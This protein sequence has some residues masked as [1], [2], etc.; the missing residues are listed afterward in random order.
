[1]AEQRRVDPGAQDVEH[2]LDSR[3]AGRGQAPQVG[4]SD[5]YRLRAERERLDH[6]ATAPDAAVEQ[7]LELVAD[8]FGDGG[9]GTDRRGRA[10]EI[11]APVVGDRDRAE[12]GV[13]GPPGVV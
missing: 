9:Q 8:R 10:V 1:Q 5:H 6:V 7:H 13:E 2:V 3:L 12:A 11:V 4:P